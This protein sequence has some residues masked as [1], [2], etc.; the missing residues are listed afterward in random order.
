MPSVLALVLALEANDVVRVELVAGGELEGRVLEGDDEAFTLTFDNRAEAV[1][2]ALVG[3]AWVNGESIPVPQLQREV[4]EFDLARQPLLPDRRWPHP[5][6]VGG[7]SILWPGTGQLLLGDVGSFVGYSAI[8]LGLLGGMAWWVLVEQNASPLVTL[9]ALSM[10][11]RIWSAADAVYVTKKR[12]STVAV[13]P[14]PGGGI[15]LY[16]SLSG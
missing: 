4:L 10:A 1:P 14:A 15:G 13:M 3:E 6:V 11:F 12:R 7:A 5:V 16:V 8:E 9:G 2:W